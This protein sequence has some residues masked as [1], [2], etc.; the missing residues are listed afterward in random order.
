MSDKAGP[1]RDDQLEGNPSDHG[2]AVVEGVTTALSW[3][4]VLPFR[5]ASVFDRITGRRAIAAIPVAGLAPAVLALAVAATYWLVTGLSDGAAPAS[6]SPRS[7][8]GFLVVGA[9]ILVA[10]QAVTRAMHLDGL[11]DVADALGSYKDP[12][13]ARE[14]L[15]DPATGPMG[16][17]AIGLTLLVEATSFGVV[18]TSAVEAWRGRDAFDTAGACV[19]LALPFVAGR[20]AA[21]GACWTRYRPFS[22]SGFGALTAGTQPGWV[23]A[24]WWAGLSAVSALFLGIAGLAACLVTAGASA[25]FTRHCNRRLGGVNGDV[26]G[27]VIESMTAVCAAVLAVAL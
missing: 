25:A 15:R 26:L 21:V 13:G 5:G 10:S 22:E 3:L 9:L 17:G 7:D 27:A 1:T 2:N 20:I 4:T 8:I 14:I 11:A 24:A 16:V 18:A 12:A 23:V 19:A 6:S